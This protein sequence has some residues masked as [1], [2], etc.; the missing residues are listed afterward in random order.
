MRYFL[1]SRKLEIL[2]SLIAVGGLILIVSFKLPLEET[3][4][5][6]KTLVKDVNAQ[7]AIVMERSSR[8]VLFEKNINKRLLPASI[9]KILSTITAI[10][11]M[12]LDHYVVVDSSILKATG[13]RIYL[14][15]GE[16]IQI[17]DLL[18]G[19]M[20]QSGNDASLVVAKAYSGVEEDFIIAMN[21]LAQ[22]IGMRNSLFNNPTGLDEGECNYSSAY[23]MALLMAYAMENQTFRK[24]T[25]TKVHRF[26]TV[27]GKS[28]VFFNKH[29][30]IQEEPDVIGGK[31]GY[32]KKA[33]RTLVT[34][35]QQDEMELIVVTFDA[36]G[37]W[38]L[39]KKLAKEAFENYHLTKI[40]S[41]FTF[42]MSTF[43][44]LTG[45]TLN[46]PVYFPLTA[47]EVFDMKLGLRENKFYLII[48]VKQKEYE[49]FLETEGD[50][51]D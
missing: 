47:E 46:K 30:L 25:K 20:L 49:L 50:S 45:K 6:H 12:D 17:R 32:T 11:L 39:H 37:D 8:R 33:G 19:M 36:H 48:K 44:L 27:D 26:V 31:T 28:Y 40:I 16:I 21:E 38:E 34:V 42:Q 43:H 35:F 7:S 1:A 29:R 23:D 51:D 9:S 3:V 18:Y 13:S 14:E 15:V 2:I 24:I 5:T 10:K 41:P 22:E 4:S